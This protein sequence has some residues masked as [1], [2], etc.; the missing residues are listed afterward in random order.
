MWLLRRGVRAAAE[1]LSGAPCDIEGVSY[2]L[3][4]EFC[5]Q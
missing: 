5:Q 2:N 4:V 3:L 1:S